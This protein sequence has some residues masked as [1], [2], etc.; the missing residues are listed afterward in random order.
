MICSG[1]FFFLPF[2]LL[3]PRRFQPIEGTHDLG[4][5]RL[6]HPERAILIE[7]DDSLFG[8][9]EVRPPLIRALP[10]EIQNRF[11]ESTFLLRKKWISFL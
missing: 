2:R 5:K 6:L 11:L 4:I 9:N 3:N 7:G 10:N 8:M 1:E